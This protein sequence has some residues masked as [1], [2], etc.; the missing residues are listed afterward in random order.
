MGL[1]LE[2]NAN[3]VTGWCWKQD[4]QSLEIRDKE[5]EEDCNGVRRCRSDRE[6]A[7]AGC[8]NNCIQYIVGVERGNVQYHILDSA[9]VKI[10]ATME[11]CKSTKT[12]LIFDSL[13]CIH[14]II[15]PNSKSNALD[16]SDAPLSIQELLFL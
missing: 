2:A 13:H 11:N 16:I 14:A 12:R 9:L 15:C 7:E 8:A 6:A 1:K 5:A 4:Y 3:I 10:K